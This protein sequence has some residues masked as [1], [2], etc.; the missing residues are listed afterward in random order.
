[1]ELSEFLEILVNT[2]A[3]VAGMWLCLVVFVCIN[4]K[5]GE[6]VTDSNLVWSWVGAAYLIA[7]L[8]HH[9]T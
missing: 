2:L 1:M 6:K 3:I 9:M 4:M 7:L 8:V 5:R